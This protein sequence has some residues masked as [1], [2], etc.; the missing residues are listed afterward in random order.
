MMQFP[1][2]ETSM[3]SPFPTLGRIKVTSECFGVYCG[4]IKS[5]CLRPQVARARRDG[6]AALAQPP[7]R[8]PRAA[9]GISAAL[10]NPRFASRV[11][12]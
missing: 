10:H 9:P 3:Y 8:T 2:A 4:A 6:A 1:K 5:R 11:P 7:S 12:K